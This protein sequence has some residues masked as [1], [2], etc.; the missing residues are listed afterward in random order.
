MESSDDRE[1]DDGDCL[2]VS[3]GEAERE[4]E[5]DEGEESMAMVW[6]SAARRG[7]TVDDM[8]KVTSFGRRREPR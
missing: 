2:G 1:V 8:F 4:F 6:S 3:F 7:L 5:V